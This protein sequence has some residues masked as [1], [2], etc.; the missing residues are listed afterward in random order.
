MAARCSVANPSTRR[1]LAGRVPLIG[2]SAGLAKA[3]ALLSLYSTAQQQGVQGAAIARGVLVDGDELPP[4]QHP[5]H[6]TVRV[7]THV[8]RSMGLSLPDDAT[9]ARALEAVAPAEPSVGKAPAAGASG[10]LP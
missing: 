10:D 2:F 1:A 6:F 8:A 9:L 5:R 7:N 3:G 4:P